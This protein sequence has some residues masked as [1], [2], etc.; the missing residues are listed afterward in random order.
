[1]KNYIS[2][3]PTFSVYKRSKVSPSYMCGGCDSELFK[4]E[5]GNGGAVFKRYLKGT[6]K[7]CAKCGC[8]V[9]I[10]IVTK[11]ESK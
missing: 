7:F 5:N 8:R 11:G 3:A 6:C 4:Y 1:M 9:S 2:D 10:E